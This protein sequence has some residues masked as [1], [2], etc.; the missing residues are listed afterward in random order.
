MIN[1]K[2][3]RNHRL[4]EQKRDDCIRLKGVVCELFV[5]DERIRIEQFIT[6][7]L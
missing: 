4:K 3:V 6:S 2:S 1:F 5:K 7:F